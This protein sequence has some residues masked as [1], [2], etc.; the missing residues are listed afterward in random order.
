MHIRSLLF[1]LISSVVS[2]EASAIAPIQHWQTSQGGQVYFVASPGL[3]MVDMRM[4]FDAGSARDGKHH[5]IASLTASLLETGA[6]QWNADQLAQRFDDVGA[7]FQYATDRDTSSVSLRTLT[8]ADLFAQAI[9]TYQTMISRP[10]FVLQEFQRIKEQRLI[11]LKQQQ[12]RPGYIAK[13]AFYQSLYAQHPYAHLEA[14]DPESIAAITLADVQQFYQQYYVRNNAVLVI[15]GDLTET[16][17]RQTAESLFK[18]LRPGVRA[19]KLPVVSLPVAGKQQHIGFSSTQTHVLAGL[20]VL[21]RKDADYFALYVGN[22]ILGGS[23]LV[24]KLF[25]EIREKRGLAYS[26]Y[27]YFSPLA[28]AGPFT[29]GLQTQNKQRTVAIEVL[30]QTLSDFIKSGPT[31]AE[32]IAAKK[33]LTGGFVLR[34]DNNRKLLNYVAMIAFYQLPLDYLQSFP[35]KVALVTTE[36]IKSAFQRRVNT[37]LLQLISVGGE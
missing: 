25:G 16:Q 6:G 29:M 18:S 13:K 7:K 23:G 5:G 27:S 35:E 9:A 28:E 20:P 19:D 36:D 24:S 14:G 26:A 11:S 37:D 2:I 4:V 31:Q 34:F 17:A 3:P 8:Q 32:L 1:F 21:S 33:N 15:V 10:Q 12:E 22:H 30:Q